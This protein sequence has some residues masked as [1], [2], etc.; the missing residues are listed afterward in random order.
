[1]RNILKRNDSIYNKLYSI[2]TLMEVHLMDF[3]EPGETDL[4]VFKALIEDL[5][6]EEVTK[7]YYY[8]LFEG[9]I[10]F[11]AKTATDQNIGSLETILILEKVE[12]LDDLPF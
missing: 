11:F 3:R 2:P 4:E 5:R 7:S 6:F 1:M 10:H 8:V 12:D 9:C